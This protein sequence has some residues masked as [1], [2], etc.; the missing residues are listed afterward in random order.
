MKSH[1]DLVKLRRQVHEK[2]AV[3]GVTQEMLARRTGI[4]KSTLSMQLR[5]EPYPTATMDVVAALM[6][7]VGKTDLTEYLK[8]TRVSKGPGR[9]LTVD[10]MLLRVLVDTKKNKLSWH[11]GKVAEAA[12]MNRGSLTGF[13]N[14]HVPTLTTENAFKLMAWLEIYDWREICDE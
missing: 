9:N 4:P 1:F 13:L 3:D 12:G 10:W 8:S 5:P 2:M 11:N 6:A 14:G 7:F